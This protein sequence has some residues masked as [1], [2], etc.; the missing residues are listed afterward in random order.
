[1]KNIIYYHELEDSKKQ[2]API[3]STEGECKLLF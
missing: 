2:N 1:M 3:I